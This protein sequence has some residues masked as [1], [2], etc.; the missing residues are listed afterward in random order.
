MTA[1]SITAAC[2]FLVLSASLALMLA[3]DCSLTDAL[4]D[5]CSSFGLGG[6]SVGVAREDNPAALFIP[7]HGD[8]GGSSRS[9]DDRIRD[10][11]APR[12]GIDTIPQRAHRG[13][14]RRRR[15]RLHPTDAADSAFVGRPGMAIS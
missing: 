2:L 14:L 5:A 9:D 6:Y 4:F 8:G 13:R 10:Q 3:S 12:L 7:R 15:Y 11:Q 1:V